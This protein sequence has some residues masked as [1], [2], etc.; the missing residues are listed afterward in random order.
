MLFFKCKQNQVKV[1]SPKELPLLLY[2]N[3]NNPATGK[4]L[5]PIFYLLPSSEGGDHLTMAKMY[6]EAMIQVILNI[7]PNLP[8][9][10]ATFLS[11]VGL[12]GR[13][14]YD[15]KRGD[16]DSVCG[17]GAWD[18]DIYMIQERERNGSSTAHGTK[19]TP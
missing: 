6:V 19:C 18:R 13:G 12:Q 16:H 17:S 3:A 5:F 10:D 11:W 14:A 9:S 8:T 7:N 2:S 15:Q 4:K 1:N